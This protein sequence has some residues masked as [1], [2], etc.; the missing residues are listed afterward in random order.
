MATVTERPRPTAVRAARL[1]DGTGG[2]WVPNPVVVMDGTTIRSVQSN[3]AVPDGAHLVDLGGATLLPGLV[4]THVH[5]VFDGT[6]G[7]VDNLAAR[8]DDATLA[9]MREAGTQLLRAGVT[10]VRDLGDRDYLSLRLRGEQ[11]MPT[12]VTAG[13][14][15][16]SP[17]GHCHFLGGCAEPTE[18]GVRAAVRRHAERGVDVIKIMASGGTL[19]PGSRQELSQF[20]AA[21]MRAAV[22]EA[23][24]LGLPVTA[25]AHG[26]PAIADA[27]AAGVDGMEHVTFWT[28]DGVDAPDDLLT[29]LA[30][31]PVV[32]GAT[33]G[34]RPM[35]GMSPPPVI[36]ARLPH[37]LAN[38]RRLRELGA[39]IVPGTDSGIGPMKPHGVLA[40]AL[41]TLWDLG[42][43]PAEA[44]R[45]ITSVAAGVCGQ[46]DRK[47]RLAEGF[48][49]DLL[50]VDGDPLADPTA[51]L[52]VRA[53]FA[54]GRRV[55]TA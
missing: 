5:L 17:D 29:A 39:S 50:A 19:T 49:A 3:G 44:L 21:A 13:P 33:V 26:T 36:V 10:T 41:P 45:L 37:V 7:A 4:D 8:D 47:G 1:F 28:A 9:A 31:S 23:H 6:A 54:R 11:A 53:V 14:P 42:F 30:D 32:I 16:T 40:Y 18:S 25:H 55:D 2:S 51:L 15:L 20:D 48:D 24:R 43:A 35:A 22:D 34:I 46:A 38:H 12:L 52:Q 27:L